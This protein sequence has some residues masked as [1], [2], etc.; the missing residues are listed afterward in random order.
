MAAELHFTG[1]IAPD[2]ALGGRPVSEQAR[3]ALSRLARALDERG[4]ALGDLLR[5]RLFVDDLGGLPA[6]EEAI[7]SHVGA[8]RPTM[9]VVELPT[10]A[11]GPGAAVTLDAV[12]APGARARRRLGPQSVRLGPWV[13]L[14]AVTAPVRLT[15]PSNLPRERRLLRES[16][17]MFAHVEELLHAQSAELRDVVKVGGWLTFP[18][19]DYGRLGETRSALVGE[20]GLLPASA[21]VQVGRVGSGDERLAFEA[22]AF[23]PE[24]RTDTL[25]PTPATASRLADFYLD[26][27][28]AGDYVFTSGEV[29]DG[30]GSPAEQAREIYE[31]LRAHL[32][33]H[34]ATPA[35]VLQQ[36]VFVRTAD[37]GES[38]SAA[39]D[40]AVITEA[41]SE[42]A[43]GFYGA[44]TN[45]PP[46]TLLPV[47]DF[48]FRPGCAVEIELVAATDAPGA[49]P[50]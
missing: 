28:A 14:G 18:M 15:A 34:R 5:L 50:R 25:Q 1:Q 26:A 10:D 35:D 19:R 43:R 49:D 16:R 33:A 2:A 22:I 21:A 6:I 13:F 30:R 11:A 8:E 29:P 9:S 17:A 42:A 36:T 23:A 37:A 38:G 7:D 44:N 20:A 24:D 31:R 27:R 39:A 4:L 45:L 40:R 46:T 32:A 47:A 41:V 12:A 48:G 3:S